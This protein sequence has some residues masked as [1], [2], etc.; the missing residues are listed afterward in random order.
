MNDPKSFFDP[1]RYLAVATN[2][3]DKIDL[4]PSPTPMTFARAAP[5]A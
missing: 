2:F 5:P 3:V 4:L 1:S